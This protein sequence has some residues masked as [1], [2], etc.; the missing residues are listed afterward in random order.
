M[1]LRRQLFLPRVFYLL[2]ILASFFHSPLIERAEAAGIKNV[3]RGT[4][5]FTSGANRMPVISPAFQPVDRTKTIVWG[6]VVHGGGRVNSA[7]PNASRIA[8]ELESDTVLAL[9]RLGSPTST[10]VVEWQAW[11]KELLMWTSPGLLSISA[12]RAAPQAQPTA[13]MM[14]P[15][16]AH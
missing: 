5:T 1:K 3:Q 12:F 8:F 11:I 4:V 6:G 9:E 16:R 13:S 7:N 2:I 15:G 10:P 14:F